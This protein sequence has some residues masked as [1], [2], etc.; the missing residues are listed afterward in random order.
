MSWYEES[1]ESYV[2]L[3][4]TEGLECFWLEH[5]HTGRFLERRLRREQSGFCCGYWA[6]VDNEA[7][8]I[9]GAL[10]DAGWAHEA[11]LALQGLAQHFGTIIPQAP[12]T[13]ARR[14]RSSER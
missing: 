2:G 9:V 5:E 7:I 3:I 14:D 1:M 13:D 4:T 11:A 8:H 10:L 6:V 12:D